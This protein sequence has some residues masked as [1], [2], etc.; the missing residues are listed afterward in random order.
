[1]CRRRQDLRRRLH[2]QRAF[3][4][5]QNIPPPKHVLVY[6]PLHF[7]H[8]NFSRYIMLTSIRLLPLLYSILSFAHSILCD[9]M[10]RYVTSSQYSDARDQELYIPMM[11]LTA[12]A[13]CLSLAITSPLA[14]KSPGKV[15]DEL[16]PENTPILQYFVYFFLYSIQTL[17]HANLVDKMISNLSYLCLQ[18]PFD[19]SFS[20]RYCPRYLVLLACDCQRCGRWC[21][22]I[23][24]SR[25]YFRKL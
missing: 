16:L 18:L 4:H 1:M 24:D 15:L 12:L 21:V 11:F 25:V 14:S 23:I 22:T 2:H 20:L 6:T 10:G 7:F 5:Q 3:P 8:P 19:I 9:C 17:P 13:T